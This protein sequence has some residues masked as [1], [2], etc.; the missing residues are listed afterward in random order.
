MSFHNTIGI[1]SKTLKAAKDKT[2]AQEA[3][4]MAWFYKHPTAMPTPWQLHAELKKLGHDLLITSIRRA[5]TDLSD[6]GQ[7]VKSDV[8]F[9]GPK[10]MPNHAWKLKR[11]PKTNKKKHQALNHKPSTKNLFELCP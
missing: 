7:L 4:I 3:L 2:N 10:G 1:A 9:K 5:L 11:L 6:S 8:L